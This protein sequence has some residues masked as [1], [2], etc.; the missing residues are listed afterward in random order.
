VKTALEAALVYP[1]WLRFPLTEAGG[2]I[3]LD[4]AA[5]PRGVLLV[6]VHACTN[7]KV[8][9]CGESKLLWPYALSALSAAWFARAHGATS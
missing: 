3:G 6:T 7:L 8:H 5:P 4:A 2:A 1:V 9:C